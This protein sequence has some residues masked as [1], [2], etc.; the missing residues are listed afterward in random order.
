MT[1]AAASLEAFFFPIVTKLTDYRYTICL[2]KRIQN[3]HSYAEPCK[4]ARTTKY[5]YAFNI[6]KGCVML[7][8][9]IAH[10]R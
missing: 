5:T 1:P 6:I 7:R 8:Q 9:S 4:A 10:I 3:S 2:G